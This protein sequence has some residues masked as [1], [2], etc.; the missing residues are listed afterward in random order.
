MTDSETLTFS[1]NDAIN[2]FGLYISDWG[3]WSSGSLV[4]SNNAG[5]SLTIATAA[6]AALLPNDNEFFF[7]IILSGFSFTEV[8]FT[9]SAQGDAYGL[10][11]I[12]YGNTAPVP[13]PAT[14]LLLGTGLVGL[15]GIR[16]KLKK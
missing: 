8:T 11:E 3:D 9:N 4:F 13:E 5:D 1:F 15:A 14:L 12:Y 16:R 10:D 7:G 2:S 6:A